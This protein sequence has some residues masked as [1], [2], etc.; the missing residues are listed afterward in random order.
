MLITLFGSQNESQAHHQLAEFA[1]QT[2]R[3]QSEL[4]CFVT[5]QSAALTQV[6]KELVVADALARQQMIVTLGELQQQVGEERSAIDD[7]HPHPH[8]L[9]RNNE[10][11]PRKE[12]K[13]L[14]LSLP[15]KTYDSAQFF[16]S[17]LSDG[18]SRCT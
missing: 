8:I 14:S 7:T 13:T 16:R 17:R 6:S 9:L 11:S 12:I 4:T 18:D 3:Q 5:D 1:R 15:P 2:V 10:F